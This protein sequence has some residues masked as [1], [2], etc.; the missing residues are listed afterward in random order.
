MSIP[1]GFKPMLATNADWDKIKFPIIV[2]PKCDGFRCLIFDGV[3][4]SR[5]LKPIPNRHVQKVVASKNGEWNGHD[6][7]LI[8]GDITDPAVFRNTSKGVMSFEGE[9]D[10][11]FYA[12]DRCDQE[13]KNLPYVERL[14]LV[15]KLL[16][17]EY[18]LVSSLEDLYTKET[19]YTQRGFEGLMVRSFEGT[20]KWGR[21]SVTEGGLLKVKRFLDA[22]ATV[23]GF[24]ERLHNANEA[25]K[26][27]LGHTKRSSHKDN[28]IPMNTL[29]SL[30]CLTTEGD[31]FR[32]GTGFNDAERDNIWC[33]QEY[34][35][36]KLAKYKY[37][38]L[39]KKNLP[40]FPVFLGWREL[41][42]L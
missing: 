20:Y 19:E 6:G 34:F 41:I 9:P 5:N 25:T 12:F 16:K 15:N 26:D 33:N 36:G 3:A 22:E 30:I 35:L 32:L 24:E 2:S 18:G 21:S 4:Y 38:D 10:F 40:R 29:G 27:N 11:H 42:D 23:I 7:E 17:L 1:T 8:V 31:E 39:G 37:T 13:F 14:A 28:M